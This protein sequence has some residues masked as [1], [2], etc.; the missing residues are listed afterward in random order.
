[1]LDK[2]TAEDFEKNKGK[3]Y[4]VSVDGGA[5]IEVTLAEVIPHKHDPGEGCRRGFSVIFEGPKA[6][7]IEG[8]NHTIT[9]EGGESITAFIQPIVSHGDKQDYELMFC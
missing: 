2:L 3:T 4:T 7:T 1:M 5:A 6:P 9:V 8:G